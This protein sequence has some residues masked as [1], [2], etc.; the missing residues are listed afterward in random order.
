M[1]MTNSNFSQQISWIEEFVARPHASAQ[2]WQR[3][4]A[5]SKEL[6]KELRSQTVTET[7][8]E[9]LKSA[10]GPAMTTETLQGFVLNKPHGYAGDY[11]IIE[12]ILHILYG[13]R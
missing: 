1:Q 7:E 4:D 8:R 12:Q 11:E 2:D 5:L 3:Y 13:A 9:A 10:F 6:G